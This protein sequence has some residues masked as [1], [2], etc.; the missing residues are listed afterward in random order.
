MVLLAISNLIALPLAVYMMHGWLQ[1]FAYRTHIGVGVL[2]IS[3][4]ATFVISLATVG[5]LSLKAA[6]A[7]PVDSL[8]H[9]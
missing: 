3:A 5:I 8:R 1:N 4:T 7:N 6:A 9:E 2:F